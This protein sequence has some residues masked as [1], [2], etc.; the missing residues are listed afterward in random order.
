MSTGDQPMVDPPFRSRWYRLDAHTPVPM[1]T[2]AEHYAEWDRREQGIRHGEDPYRVARTQLD[3]EHYVSTVFLGLDNQWLADGPPLLFETMVFPE[4]DVCERYSTW[5]Q[6]VAGHDQVVARERSDRV[7]GD[8]Q[9][10][11]D[12]ANILRE[13]DWPGY[14]DDE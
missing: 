3:V 11:I 8:A 7:V 2:R 9:K 13:A 4:C 6:A 1:H 14:R 10:V 5:D 12:V